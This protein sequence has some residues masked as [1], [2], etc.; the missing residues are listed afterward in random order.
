MRNLHHAV[1]DLIRELSGRERS[2]SA[3][4]SRLL[5]CDAV[6]AVRVET[7]R[8]AGFGFARD[9]L[10]AVPES[11]HEQ[12]ECKEAIPEHTPWLHRACFLD[13]ADGSG[14]PAWVAAPIRIDGQL[15]GVIFVKLIKNDGI[16]EWQ[17]QVLSLMGALS[18][19]MALAWDRVCGARKAHENTIATLVRSD[20]QRALGEMAAGMAHEFNQPLT[21]IRG[22]AEHI[23]ICRQRGW[24]VTDSELDGRLQNIIDLVDRMSSLIDHVRDFAR[25]SDVSE[26]T[27]IDPFRVVEAALRLVSAQFRN[28]G[29]EVKLNPC[30]PVAQVRVNPF[31]L[32]EILLHLLNNARDAIDALPKYVEERTVTVTSR[33]KGEVAV[34]E[35]ADTGIGLSEEVQEKAF[36][37]FY[38][39]KGPTGGQGVGLAI[40]RS[41]C[42][43]Y[44]GAAALI[45]AQP[46]GAIARLMLPQVKH[47]VASLK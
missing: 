8:P 9:L 35:I 36:D 33:I 14:Y 44:G 39:T 25:N 2:L 30:T 32:E 7:I 20:R 43:R 15:L 3:L 28:H 38:T 31:S 13:N 24:P 27:E 47:A 16:A 45:P 1:H 11:E 12:D 23:L 17:P 34:I 4:L 29:I 42:E 6:M 22:F 41:L 26:V 37:P 40:V 46:R 5:A 10:A 21:G 19:A 18:S